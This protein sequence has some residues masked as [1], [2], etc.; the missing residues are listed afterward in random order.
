[1]EQS[2]LI[3]AVKLNCPGRAVIQRLNEAIALVRAHA[4]ETGDLTSVRLVRMLKDATSP[5]EIAEAGE[6]FRAWAVER[7]LGKAVN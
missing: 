3:P 6:T 4:I 1:M 5:D 7:G 2:A